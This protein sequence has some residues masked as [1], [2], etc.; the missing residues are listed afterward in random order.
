MAA[1]GLSDRVVSDMEMNMKQRCVMT[2]SVQKIL[3]FS[4]WHSLML[5]EHLRR[6]N[7]EHS[8]A[9]GDINFRVTLIT[10]SLLPELTTVLENLILKF[11]LVL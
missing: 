2:P 5:P 6:P 9:I 3:T 11:N 1:E 7:S 4:H 10:L 8:E